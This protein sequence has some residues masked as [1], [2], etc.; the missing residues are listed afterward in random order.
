[1]PQQRRMKGRILNVL[2]FVVMGTLV[3]FFIA[4]LL[5][6]LFNSFKTAL[7]IVKMP[8]A[9]I[10][11]PTLENY[12]NVFGAQ[13]F[14]KYMWNSLAVAGGSVIIG[15]LLGLP[16]AFSIARYKQHKLAVLILISR[17]VPGI[18]FLLPLFIMFRFFGLV[19]TYFSLI[20]S[21]LLVGL[22]FIVWVM[23]PFFEAIPPDLVDAARVDGCSITQTFFRVILPISGSGIVTCSILA[24]IFS[25]NN[26]MFSIILASNE[27]KTVPVAIFNFIAF[28]TIDW[29]GLMAASV[30]ITLPVLAITL[31]TQKYVIRGLTSG[32]VKG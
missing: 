27:T 25:W 26:F 16:A 9:L 24:F 11:S 15:L 30:V 13:N 21:H 19:D 3:F 14:L 1:M 8:P 5:W 20:L 32:A 17:I 29:G 28:A 22:P 6:M 7:D 31:I 10:F 23:V 18:T 2:Y 4:P 12:R